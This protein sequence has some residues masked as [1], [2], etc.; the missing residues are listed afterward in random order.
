M[1]DKNYWILMSHCYTLGNRCRNELERTF[2][3]TEAR[4]QEI[5][6]ADGDLEGMMR[7]IL[8]ETHAYKGVLS[9]QEGYYAWIGTRSTASVLL[10]TGCHHVKTCTK[11]EFKVSTD[12]VRRSTIEASEWGK[13]FL[14]NIWTNSRKEISI[15]ESMKNKEKVCI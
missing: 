5:N 9:T 7:W 15:E 11:L 3:S 14:S 4:S 12:S 8:S 10:K 13:M 1:G 2:S 6:F